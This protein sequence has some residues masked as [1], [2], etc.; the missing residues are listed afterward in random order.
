MPRSRSRARPA[1]VPN[2]LRA[3][4]A[5]VAR[6]VPLARPPARLLVVPGTAVRRIARPRRSEPGGSSGEDVSDR[7]DPQ[8]RTGGPRWRREDHRWPRRCCSPPA[9]SPAS[10]GSRTAPP[11]A[12][13]T[14][15]SSAATSPCRSRSR[16]SSST[17][18]RST[19]LDTPGYADFVGDVV[20][21]LQAADLALF[22]VSAVEGVEVQTEVAWKLAEAARHPARDL[23]QQARPRARVVRSARSTSSRT[24]FGAGVAPLQLPIGEEADLRG[25]VELL[26]DVAVTYPAA[27]RRAPRVRCPTRWQTRSTRC[28]T[29]SIEGIVVGDDDLMERY[30]G[31]ETID[32]DEL[33]QALGRRHRVGDACSRCCAAARRSSI[34]VDRLAKFLVEEAPAPHA[35]TATAGA[36]RVQDDRRPVRRAREP[37]QGAAGHGEARRRAHERPVEDRRAHAPAVHDARQGAGRRS[38]EVAAGDIAAVAKLARHRRP[39]T[40][41]RRRARRSRSS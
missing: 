18:T 2:A 14:P 22:V 20:A 38:N 23:R 31:D 25:V 6:P 8:R 33:A 7:E 29:R 11:C 34:G 35:S 10:A 40:C 27:R 21:A 19:S 24:K 26:N 30:L 5:L 4:R 15:K 12:T 13:S 28:T 9:R 17:A 1:T 36:R 3:S 32:I 37:V 41:S 16:R 39:A